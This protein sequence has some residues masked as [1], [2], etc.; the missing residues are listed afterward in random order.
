MLRRLL[1]GCAVAIALPVS[2]AQGAP[3]ATQSVACNQATLVISF[4][5]TTA[6]VVGQL[7]Q[8]GGSGGVASGTVT[9]KLTYT[10]CVTSP[11]VANL[12]VKWDTGAVSRLHAK[13]TLGSDFFGYPVLDGTGRVRKG[14]FA[15]EKVS[16]A[17]LGSNSAICAYGGW[18][19]GLN[20]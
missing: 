19:G 13:L 16:I 15:G 6:T 7:A 3:A 14:A 8:C 2:A 1:F 20:A 11:F 12:R 18:S 17:L 9:G 4:A 10:D 5:A